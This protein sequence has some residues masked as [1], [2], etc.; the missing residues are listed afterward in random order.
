MLWW[1]GTLTSHRPFRRW[2]SNLPAD[3]LVW[4]LRQWSSLGRHGPPFLTSTAFKAHLSAFALCISLSSAIALF[5]PLLSCP[6]SLKA[7]GPPSDGWPRSTLLPQHSW[8][9]NGKQRRK[10]PRCSGPASRRLPSS[11]EVTNGS[12]Q[13]RQCAPNL[14]LSPCSHTAPVT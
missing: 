11:P 3:F 4:Y 7:A 6:R 9:S 5:D 10:S 8:W 12:E 2:S 14:A 1:Q 13:I